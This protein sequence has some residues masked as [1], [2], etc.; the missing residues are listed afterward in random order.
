MTMCHGFRALETSGTPGSSVE[1]ILKGDYR[2]VVSPSIVQDNSGGNDDK[3]RAVAV[4]NLLLALFSTIAPLAVASPAPLITGFSTEFDAFFAPSGNGYNWGHDWRA[5]NYQNWVTAANQ[6][7]TASVRARELAGKDYYLKVMVD[8][9][10]LRG[11]DHTIA[12]AAS[13]SAREFTGSVYLAEVNPTANTIRLLRRT[14]ALVAERELD[15]IDLSDLK[16]FELELTG[17]FR[18]GIASLTFA[19]RKEGMEDSIAATD[20]NP[21]GGSFFG[22]RNKNGPG[23]ATFEVHFDNLEIRALHSAAFHSSAP[24]AAAIGQQFSYTPVADG[25]IELAEAPEWLTWDAGKLEGTPTGEDVGHATIRFRSTGRTGAIATQQVAL[26]VLASSVET[27]MVSIERGF[28]QEGFTTEIASATDGAKLSYTLDGS[29]PSLENGT[30]VESPTSVAIDGTTILRVRAFLDGLAPSPVETQSYLFLDDIRDQQ[31]NGR[32]PEGWPTRPVNSQVFNFGM[33]RD[34]TGALADGAFEQAMKDIATI[35]VATDLGNLVDPEIGIWVNAEDRGREAER[36]VSIELIGDTEGPGF[37]I[38]AGARIRGGWSR[39]PVNPKHAFHLYFRKDYGSGRLRYPLFGDEGSDSFDRLDLRTTQGRSWHSSATA[40]ATFNRDVFGRHIQRDMGQPYTRSRYYHLYLNGIYFGLYQSQERSDKA[41]AASYFGGDPSNFDVIKTRT[42]P[43]RVEALDGDADAWTQL[44]DAAV[45]GFESDSAYLAV[46]G[47]DGENPNLLDV[48]NLIDYM[49]TIIFTGQSDGP[50]N[51]RANVPKNFFA[52]RAR[53]GSF[54]FRFFVHDNE[55][56]LQDINADSTINNDTGSRLTQFN[57]KWLHQQLAKNENYRN[58]FSDRAHRHLFN[59]GALDPPTAIAN[60]LGTA[61]TLAHA[62]VGESARWGDAGRAR[63]YTRTDWQ[64]AVAGKVDTWIPRRNE[65]VIRQLRRRNLYPDLS[66]PTFSQHGGEVPAGIELSISAPEGQIFYTVDGTDPMDPG[67]QEFTGGLECDVLLG[68]EATDWHYLLTTDT[69]SS[70]RVVAGDPNYNADDWKHGDFDD[71]AWPVGAA[72]LG[73]GNVGDPELRTEIPDEE[74]PRRTTVY[75]RRTFNVAGANAYRELDINIRRD[76]GAIVYLNGREI[77][78]SNMPEGEVFFDTL[79]AK[80]ES[81]QEFHYF[82]HAATIEPGVLVE[83]SNTL[84]VEVHQATT[85]SGDLV[86][87]VELIGKRNTGGIRIDQSMTLKARAF[88]D[89]EWSALT[90]AL[91]YT[92]AAPDAS[93]LAVTEIYYNPPGASEGTEYIEIQNTS[94]DRAIHLDGLA[95]V[96]G[97]KFSFSPGQILDPGERAVIVNDRPSFEE[98]F[99]NGVRILGE[100]DGNLN[101]DGERLLL[102]GVGSVSFDDRFP[103]PAAADGNGRSLV[104]TGGAPSAPGNWRASAGG[105]GSPGETDTIPFEGG[106]F[107]AYA[108][109]HHQPE[110]MPGKV[111]GM[112]VNLAA[113]GVH[114]ELQ[115][116]EDLKSWSPDNDSRFVPIGERLLD[117]TFSSRLY[118]DTKPG[119][120]VFL[121]VQAKF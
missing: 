99:G 3:K 121:R 49:L 114:Y 56:S 98:A 117:G 92:T 105:G 55:D 62:I 46:Q 74:I 58:R 83:G 48:D 38:D 7:V 31:A 6:T 44:Y 41:F 100:F 76:D 97:V 34:V 9:V 108:F 75:L 35:S 111:F 82:P 116:S 1:K 15:H 96:D 102:Q 69:L 2:K 61:E 68:R 54:G 29:T 18:D 24:K 57:P 36:P 118:R 27:P 37:Q 112:P 28:F 59:G 91:F 70:S 20:E 71:P 90:E 12:L 103:W 22:L 73:Y 21:V 110:I 47:L 30:V 63:P 64:R 66:A 84:A 11:S 53:D 60:F 72:P 79:A 67:A 13:G 88:S 16:P 52:I 80:S 78:R 42:R 87:D 119:N 43:H 107:K 109:G 17:I 19:V 120:A 86:I 5:K 23:V 85:G 26:A 113:D 32:P 77:A 89:G 10:E 8:P 81:A 25:V 51:L 104:F 95:F 4:R 101:N 106:D 45:R 115:L 94:A 50:V 14:R 93:N 33:D 39:R 40:D 65:I